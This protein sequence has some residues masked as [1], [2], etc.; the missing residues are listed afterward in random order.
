MCHAAGRFLNRKQLTA[1]FDGKLEY[2][3]T[4]HPSSDLNMK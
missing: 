3:F 2:G 1:D 4:G